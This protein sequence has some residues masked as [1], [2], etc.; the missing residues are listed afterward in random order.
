MALARQ[1]QKNSALGLATRNALTE[2]LLS[3]SQEG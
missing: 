1:T 3:H 2:V